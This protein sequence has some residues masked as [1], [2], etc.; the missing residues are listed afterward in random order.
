M[1]PPTFESTKTL[2]GTRFDDGIYLTVAHV[3]PVLKDANFTHT[4]LARRRRIYEILLYPL[5]RIV[6]VVI[7]GTLLDHIIHQC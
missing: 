2:L 3:V 5:V 1:V 7:P 4:P 6:V